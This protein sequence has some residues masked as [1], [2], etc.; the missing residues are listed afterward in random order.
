MET[1][2]R[3]TGIFI[4][5][6]FVF[7][8]SCSPTKYVGENEYLLH[9]I[10]VQT[11]K[12]AVS[13]TEIKRN[14]RQKPN[15]RILGLARFRLG[16][17]N[18]SGKKDKRI[19]RWLRTQGEAPVIYDAY[20]TERSRSQIEMLFNNKG[21][22]H[23]VVEDTVVF[24]KK[25][26]YATY[27][28]QQ[29]EPVLIHEFGYKDRYGYLDNAV[30]DSLQVMQ[31]IFVDTASTL[32]KVGD[33]LDVN[34]LESERDRIAKTLREKGY[35]NFSKHFIQY[36]ADTARID[37][38]DRA[39][40]LLAVVHNIPD[41]NAYQ[42]YYIREVNI[43]FD[44]DP[45]ANLSGADS[46]YLYTEYL[47][48]PIRYREKLKIRPKLIIETLQFTPGEQYN[49]KKVTE[50]YT[51]LQAL[52]L[53]K[54]V[55]LVFRESEYDNE[56]ICDVQLIPL[57]RQTYDVFLEGTHNTGNI[58]VGGN[59]SYNHRNLFRSGEN[60]TLS[61][62][63]ALRKESLTEGAIAST[64]EIGAE[65]KLV[66]P[67]FWLPIFKLE[68]FRKNYAP[69]TSVSL[70]F[71]YESTPFFKR[72]IFGMKFGYFWRKSDKKWRYNFD[73]IDL[74]YVLMKDV[75]SDFLGNLQ[76]AYIKS[77]Y[78]SHLIFSSNFTAI[79]S[80]Q[81]LNTPGSFNYFRGNLETSGNLLQGISKLLRH[82]RVVDTDVTNEN[83]EDRYH[84]IFKVRYAQFVKA[85]G[86]Y[87]F[88]QYINRANSVVYRFF[89]GC[90]YP[91][92][93]MKALPFEEAYYSGGANGIRAWQSRTLGPGSYKA[94]ESYP[95]SVGDFK[96]EANVEYR[97]KLFW[98]LEGALFVDAGNVWNINSKYEDRQGAVLRN[99]F[100]K[101]VAVGTGAG[102]RLDASFVLL[103]FDWGIKV[104]DPS[105]EEGNRFVLLDNG[106]W[107]S[108]TTFN[109]AIGYPF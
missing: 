56:L 73:L 91:Y 92:G 14:I 108:N 109:I 43:Q 60:M 22:H 97:F 38:P 105:K 55:N 45:L 25:K 103:R 69:K 30:P 42:K 93:N 70:S 47:G 82:T 53:F 77:A 28:I 29:G 107:L 33:R 66:T 41:S 95:N 51:R 80:N 5:L 18:L 78:T 13:K 26:A 31:E 9:R 94:E 76:N 1:L 74:N 17:Y 72:R 67:Q 11:D 6:V 90:G 19:N 46:L 34:V 104:K 86:E 63:G 71:S 40:L 54:F 99:D 62:W 27:K 96:L 16:M 7:F 106:K 81:V 68:D 21:F 39:Q 87:R 85:D 59:F 36:Y 61:F 3:Y 49:A 32:V 20:L 44:Y 98:L 65:I 88:N 35:F 58:G 23:V 4:V 15:T 37:Q 100:Y 75:D 52:N 89:V 64:R 57:K 24:K 50:T 8:Y 12:K 84:R 2:S 83:Y 101:Q 102:L 48:Y 79:Y 10:K